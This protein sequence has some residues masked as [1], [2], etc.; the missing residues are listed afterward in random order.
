MTR[1]PPLS[2]A[3]LGP[4]LIPRH[5]GSAACALGVMAPEGVRPTIIHRRFEPPG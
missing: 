2:V 1:P 5:D 4:S 3:Q